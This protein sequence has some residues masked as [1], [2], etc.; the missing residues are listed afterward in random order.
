[1]S[2]DTAEAI[3][4]L[5]LIYLW[6]NEPEKVIRDDISFLFEKEMLLVMRAYQ[7]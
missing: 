3:I 5:T 2:D 7:N 1:M 4:A 6:R